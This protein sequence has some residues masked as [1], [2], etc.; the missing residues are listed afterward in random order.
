MPSYSTSRGHEVIPMRGL[1][2]IVRQPIPRKAPN[3]EVTAL[4][5][6]SLSSRSR[7]PGM[8]DES[9]VVNPTDAVD[10]VVAWH[11]LAADDVA[12]RLGVDP[13]VGL[14]AP[15]VEERQATWGPNRLRTTPP[16]P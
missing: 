14:S 10:A 11:A 9:P 5:Q 12:D 6:P 8:S 7:S 1:P 4:L 3:A 2:S 13:A 16:P 15:E